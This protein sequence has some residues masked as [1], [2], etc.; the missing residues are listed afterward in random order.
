MAGVDRN[1]LNDCDATSG[2]G[3]SHRACS[4]LLM[5]TLEI[6]PLTLT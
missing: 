4:L 5:N 3:P 6:G 2:P 1:E